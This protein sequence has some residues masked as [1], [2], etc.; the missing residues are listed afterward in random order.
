MKEPER[1]NTFLNHKENIILVIV[2]Y[3]SLFILKANKHYISI[4]D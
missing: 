1:H 2:S 4:M 3:S